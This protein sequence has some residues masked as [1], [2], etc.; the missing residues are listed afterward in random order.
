M[1]LLSKKLNPI[2]LENN[3]FENRQ[4][5]NINWAFLHAQLMNFHI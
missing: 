2:A 1:K 3:Q 5:N 4:T